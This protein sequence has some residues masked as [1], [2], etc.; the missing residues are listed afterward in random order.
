MNQ[1]I[2]NRLLQLL[3]D[4]HSSQKALFTGSARPRD[5]EWFAN[6]EKYMHAWVA[7]EAWVS[8]CFKMK[9]KIEP[10]LAL[11][12]WPDSMW[13]REILDGM[14]CRTWPFGKNYNYYLPPAGPDKG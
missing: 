1:Q 7:I 9:E 4:F 2:H 14:E 5:D 3:Q 10:H 12:Q 6:A 8:D 11:L 13:M